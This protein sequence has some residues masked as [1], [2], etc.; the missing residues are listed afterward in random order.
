[1][2]D[3]CSKIL[4]ISIDDG[5]ES[6]IFVRLGV[7]FEHVVVR[8]ENV[9]RLVSLGFSL[10]ACKKAAGHFAVQPWRR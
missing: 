1:M 5:V 8:V 3:V 7:F 9:C 6:V 4:A 2:T 10:P